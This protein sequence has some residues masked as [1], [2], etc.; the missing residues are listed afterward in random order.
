MTGSLGNECKGQ[1]FFLC[2]FK[3]KERLLGSIFRSRFP[4]R[5]GI[6]LIAVASAA[7]FSIILT[8][9]VGC[10]AVSIKVLVHSLSYP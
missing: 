8:A 6:L 9:F 3:E 5:V 4:I 1:N 10:K 2:G 7:V